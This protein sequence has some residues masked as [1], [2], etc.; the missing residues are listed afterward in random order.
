[1]TKTFISGEELP[2]AT[3]SAFCDK[4]KLESIGILGINKGMKT[5]ASIFT[6][7]S[8]MCSAFDSLSPAS[9]NSKGQ[10]PGGVE[11]SFLFHGQK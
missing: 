4:V 10:N 6:R 1:M 2:E 9:T 3:V 7:E 11:T 5:S 8:W